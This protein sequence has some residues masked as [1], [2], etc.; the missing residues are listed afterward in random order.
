MRPRH[1]GRGERHQGCC[2]IRPNSASMRPRHEGRGELP[3]SAEARRLP[4]QASMRPRH[5]GRGERSWKCG[6]RAA[7]MGFN[8]ATARRP[9]R[10]VPPILPELL[11]RL[12]QC[13]HGTK[14]VENQKVTLPTATET[15]ASM[16]PRHE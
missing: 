7:R 14:A 12:L 3:L 15:L 8:A 10:T 1:E 4:A 13:G 11:T 2:K 9:W 16:R 6:N 5:E